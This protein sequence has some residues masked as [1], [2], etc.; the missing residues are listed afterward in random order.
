M[1]VKYRQ[2][3][4]NGVGDLHG[5]LTWAHICWPPRETAKLNAAL[6]DF[7]SGVAQSVMPV[8]QPGIGKTR[9]TQDPD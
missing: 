6:E 7:L 8:G 1:R 3:L 2:P 4:W 5:E 9:T